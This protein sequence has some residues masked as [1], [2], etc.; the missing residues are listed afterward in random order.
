MKILTVS[1]IV[2]PALYN[3]FEEEK[4]MD[5]D[6]ILSCG[7]LPPEYL[8]FLA[9]K[10]NA[11]LYY[12]KGNHDIR[13][14]TKPPAGCQN[15]DEKL[16][17]FKWLRIIGLEGSRWY[18]GNQNQYTEAAMRSKIRRIRYGLWRSGGVDIV[19][20][21]ASPRFIHDADDLCHRGFKC[22]RDLIDRYKPA[23]FIHG[24][25]HTNF[26]HESQRTTII[27]RTEVINTFGWYILNIELSL[28]DL[29]S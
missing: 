12:V 16:V 22:F 29:K 14:E 11:P 1:D 7:D 13:Y 18:N 2:V 23:C 10:I 17:K 6:L 8:S 27:D 21:H 19:I 28:Q 25:I 3:D 26:T 24:H 15:I 5:V 4:F 20:T 9:A